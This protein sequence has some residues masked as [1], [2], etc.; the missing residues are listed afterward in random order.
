MGG[1]PKADANLEFLLRDLPDQNSARLF[2]DRLGNEQPR[3][4]QNLLRQPPLLADNPVSY[5][6]I[7]ELDAE[8]LVKFCNK[9]IALKQ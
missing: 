3:A 4:H 2:I 9:L 1:V 5:N 7:D 8:S 6:K